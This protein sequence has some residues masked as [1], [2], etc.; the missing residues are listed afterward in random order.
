MLLTGPISHTSTHHMAFV[1]IVNIA[2]DLSAIYF[3][4]FSWCWA[5]FV[6]SCHSIPGCYNLFSIVKLSIGSFCFIF[7]DAQL[8]ILY[9]YTLPCNYFFGDAHVKECIKVQHKLKVHIPPLTKFRPETPMGS[10]D[11]MQKIS[12]IGIVVFPQLSFFSFEKSQTYDVTWG[13]HI[14]ALYGRK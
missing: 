12:G 5:F 2:L 4:Q 1:E 10:K 11:H 14:K 3:V 7:D 9:W 13:T 6:Y 8:F